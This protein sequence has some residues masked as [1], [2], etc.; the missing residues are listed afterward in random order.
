MRKQL[1]VSQ[2]DERNRTYI[3]KEVLDVLPKGEFLSWELDDNGCI[4]VFKGHLNILR[5]S[6]KCTPNGENN[7]STS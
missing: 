7:K 3:P 6:N 4:C 5:N 1:A 2:I